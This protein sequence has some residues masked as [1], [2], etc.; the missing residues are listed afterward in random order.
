V[1]LVV[2]GGHRDGPEE[3]V[4]AVRGQE[5]SL[6]TISGGDSTKERRLVTLGNMEGS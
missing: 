1:M 5:G 2:V 6:L 3:T 4:L